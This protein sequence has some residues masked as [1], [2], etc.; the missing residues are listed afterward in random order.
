MFKL[1]I[2]PHCKTIFRY[3]DVNRLLYKK[4]VECYHCGKKFRVSR[5]KFFI[6][7]LIIALITAIVDAFELYV[8]EDISFLALMLTNIITVFIGS[9]LLPYFCE[10]KG[11]K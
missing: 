11:E 4:N 10:F 3:K 6:L 8:I 5:K 2:C 1:P 9:L 7:F